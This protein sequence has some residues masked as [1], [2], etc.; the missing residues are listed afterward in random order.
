[1]LNSLE[2]PAKPEVEL[3]KLERLQVLGVQITHGVQPEE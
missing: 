2:L 1:M 3:S